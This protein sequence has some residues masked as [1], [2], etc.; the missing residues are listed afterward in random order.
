MKIKYQSV[1]G[2]TISIINPINIAGL[3][4]KNTNERSHAKIGVQTKFMITEVYVNL[5]FLKAFFISWRGICKKVMYSI[6]TN[7][8]TMNPSALSRISSTYPILILIIT[9]K[10]I[11]NVYSFSNKPMYK[12]S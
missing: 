9:A 6:A 11:I 10:K 4:P 7:R 2:V 3:L 1:Q 5:M 8:E 12:H